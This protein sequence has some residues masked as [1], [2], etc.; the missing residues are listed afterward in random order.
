M[1]SPFKIGLT[2]SIGMGKSTTAAMFEDEGIPVWDA[3]AAVHRLYAPGGKAVEPMRALYPAAI[4]DGSVSRHRLKEWISGD[5]SA[6]KRIE[7]I[8]HPLVGEDR[9][10]FIAETKAPIVLF[11]I[12]L[13][14]ETGAAKTMDMT[15]VVSA[16]ATEQRRRVMARPG[17]TAE[18]F[19]RIL[20]QQLPDAEKRARADVVI[21]TSTLDGA[22]EQV[23]EVLERIRNDA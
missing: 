16:S 18:Q 12:P 9:T 23:R 13:L 21:D 7:S 15:I 2:G 3:D 5:N 1:T 19:L 22:R 11:D 4:V 20:A 14:F 17:M 10:Q 8:V 6:L